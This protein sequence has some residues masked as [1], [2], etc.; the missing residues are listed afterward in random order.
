MYNE[1]ASVAL[2]GVAVD[3]AAVVGDPVGD[4]VVGASVVGALVGDI[5]VGARVVGACV[6]D[7]DGNPL[8]APVDVG[9]E[10]VDGAA[11]GSGGTRQPQKSLVSAVNIAHSTSPKLPAEAINSNSPQLKPCIIVIPVMLSSKVYEVH[12]GSSPGGQILQE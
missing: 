3:G 6:G 4:M 8:G 10:L 9:D 2:V 7:S 5:V 1:G 12:S 11:L